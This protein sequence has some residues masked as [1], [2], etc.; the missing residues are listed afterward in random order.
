M[1]S[2]F[3]KKIRF[4][5]VLM[6]N[7]KCD[8]MCGELGDHPISISTICIISTISSY[9]N[10]FMFFVILVRVRVAYLGFIY[11]LTLI[12]TRIHL[13]RIH[14]SQPSQLGPALCKSTKSNITQHSRKGSTI[15]LL[16]Q[17]H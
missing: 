7:E 16:S 6:K 2:S 3:I 17:W 15:S 1:S 9:T 12:L 10:V 14:L 11:C 8:F 13:A 4:V 5:Y